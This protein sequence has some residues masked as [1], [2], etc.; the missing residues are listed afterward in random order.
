MCGPVT[1]AAQL[2]ALGR[3]ATADTQRGAVEPAGRGR[4]RKKGANVPWTTATTRSSPPPPSSTCGL[5]D[6]RGGAPEVALLWWWGNRAKRITTHRQRLAKWGPPTAGSR[7]KPRHRQRARGSGRSD[8]MARAVKNAAQLL[9]TTV[10]A[11]GRARAESSDNGATAPCPSVA[12]PKDALQ[13]SSSR[14]LPRRVVPASKST[15]VAEFSVLWLWRD[16]S[17]RSATQ[18]ERAA[19]V[20]ATQSTRRAN[21]P[22]RGCAVRRVM[23]FL[24]TP[25]QKRHEEVFAPKGTW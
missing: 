15:T 23:S 12:T 17:K 24:Y 21:P 14:G 1:G 25:V 11:R 10:A 2:R 9:S 20:G 19:G 5:R 7:I 22:D 8:P 16:R 6:W 4:A 13:P 18:R 3:H